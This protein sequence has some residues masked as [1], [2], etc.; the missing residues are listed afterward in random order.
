MTPEQ[1][2]QG[3]GD[4]RI[5]YRRSAHVVQ[6]QM[7]E[8]EKQFREILRLGCISLAKWRPEQAID[9]ARAWDHPD[10]LGS[11]GL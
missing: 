2:W 10:A 3:F 8:A 11:T 7:I 1:Y 9:A 4:G 5:P 6:R